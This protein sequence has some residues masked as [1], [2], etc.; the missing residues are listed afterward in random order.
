MLLRNKEKVILKINENGEYESNIS[1]VSLILLFRYSVHSYMVM[2]FIKL[3]LFNSFM[4]EVLI[5]KK[6]VQLFA[7]QISGL[8]SI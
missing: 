1:A 7:E 6:P 8:V 4:T 2:P 5:I 3:L